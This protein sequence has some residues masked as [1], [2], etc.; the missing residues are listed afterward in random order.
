MPATF[1]VLIQDDL[2]NRAILTKRL[3]LNGHI[4]VNAT[5]GQEGLTQI[6]ADQEF[7]AILMDIQ[8]AIFPYLHAQLLTFPQDANIEWF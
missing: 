2:I 6:E 1:S 8:S 7:D 3:R 4:V 5:N